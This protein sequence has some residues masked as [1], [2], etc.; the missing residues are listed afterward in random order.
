MSDIFYY[1]T[2]FLLSRME[3]CCVARDWKGYDRRGYLATSLGIKVRVSTG[4]D[5]QSILRAD[6]GGWHRIVSGMF[7]FGRMSGALGTH[8]VHAKY[9]CGCGTGLTYGTT[10]L[11]FFKENT[12]WCFESNREFFPQGLIVLG[13]LVF[14]VQVLEDTP[15]E[16]SVLQ[17]TRWRGMPS[18]M[19][20]LCRGE[21]RHQHLY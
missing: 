10:N 3:Q 21:C 11:Y 1:H 5:G 18:D 19:I 6:H 7:L 9:W 8:M 13:W 16:Y 4:Y 15:S 20:L 14:L 12:S 2:M 17:H